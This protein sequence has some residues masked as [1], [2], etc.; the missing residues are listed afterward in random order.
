MNS[1]V[2]LLL[3]YLPTVADSIKA[4]VEYAPTAISTI[5][6]LT[7][8]VQRTIEALKQEV[9]LTPEQEAELD[10]IIDEL[11]AQEH[12]KPSKD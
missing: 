12:W 8:F 4:L 9:P 10:R 5:K 3:K 1:I 6:E 11:P 7:E 2:P